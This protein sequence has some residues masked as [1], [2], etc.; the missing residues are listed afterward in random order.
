[1]ILFVDD[2][3]EADD[4]LLSEHDKS[5]RSG[6]DA[7]LGHMPLSPR[8]PRNLLSAGVDR[9]AEARVK[10]LERPGANLTLHD[11]LTGQLSVRREIFMA[12]G[13]FNVEFTKGGSFGN[14]DVDFGYRLLQSGYKVVF[15]ARAITWQNYCVTPEHFLRQTRQSGRADVLFALKHPKERETLFRL[16]GAWR[17]LDRWLWKPGVEFPAI[18]A[19]PF[20][21]MRFAAL[22]L[23]EYGNGPGLHQQIISRLFYS[24]RAIEYWSGVREAGGIPSPGHVHVLAYH[25]IQDLS[26]VSILEPYGVP[27]A[28]FREHLE[29]LQA[30][31]FKFL[32]GEEFIRY[33]R[34]EAG[35]PGKAVLLTFDD[36]YQSIFE[37]AGLLQEHRIPAI[38][39]AV[40]GR[41]GTYNQWDEH[42]GAA[43]LP[44]LDVAGLRALEACGIE[45]GGHSRTHANFRNLKADKLESEIAGCADEL[46]RLGVRRPR[47][48]AYPYGVYTRQACDLARKAGFEAAFT[49]EAGVARHSGDPYLVPRIEILNRDNKRSFRKKLSRALSTSERT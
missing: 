38:A 24:V 15:N 48:F 31:G 10:R 27:P 33:Q 20:K 22:R 8:A 14:E 41:T 42:L 21:A 37:I 25:A 9:W 34:Q 19:A 29:E 35:V 12:A 28:L 49:I 44:L 6:A 39:F 23:F 4:Q 26:G 17:R 46:K 11:L 43:K 7:V 13:G 36:C 32:S 5:H 18:T 1:V 47:F 2:D 16:N 30:Q 40:S 45:I 3:M